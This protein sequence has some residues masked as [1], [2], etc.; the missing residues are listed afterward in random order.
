MMSRGMAGEVALTGGRGIG[1]EVEG[2]ALVSQ[3]G[4]GVRYDLDPATAIIS[5]RDHDL[6][7]QS[8]TGKVL[9]FAAPKGGIAASWTLADLRQRG[10]APAAII[11]ERAS[12]IFVQGALFAGLTLMHAFAEPACRVLSSGQRVIL[13]PAAG[14]VLFA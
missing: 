1:L 2:E 7:S 6:F 14:R 9:V 13:Q 3:Q 8:I 12:P 10:L 5:N 11:F 4:F